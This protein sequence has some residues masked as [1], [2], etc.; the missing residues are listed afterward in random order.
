M[1]RGW[2]DGLGV[3]LAGD[4]QDQQGDGGQP[5]AVFDWRGNG[6]RFSE[7]RAVYRRG[8]SE[9]FDEREPGYCREQQHEHDRCGVRGQRVQCARAVGGQRG[10]G[11]RVG[12]GLRS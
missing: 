7:S 9:R 11:D 12:I 2:G 5:Q 4:V 6:R 3:R 8:G 1:D 10:R